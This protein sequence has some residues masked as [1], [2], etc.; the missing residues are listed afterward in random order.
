LFSS[1]FTSADPTG[2]SF[3]KT[4]PLRTAF[5]ASVREQHPIKLKN[6]SSL[7]ITLRSKKKYHA[8]KQRYNADHNQS[9]P[10][11]EPKIILLFI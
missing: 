5:F 8:K 6:L 4:F 7:T 11:S 1:I 9:D 3:T 2:I 10:K